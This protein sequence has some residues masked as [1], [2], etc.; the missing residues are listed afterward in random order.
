MGAA[1]HLVACDSTETSTQD[2]RIAT[3]SS[4]LRLIFNLCRGLTDLSRPYR[5]L[6]E[7][8]TRHFVRVLM[9]M[10]HNNH[11]L[12]RFIEINAQPGYFGNIW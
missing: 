10:F 5:I 1:A 12:L 4:I 2:G 3:A 8:R 9:L 11:E 6:R 7:V